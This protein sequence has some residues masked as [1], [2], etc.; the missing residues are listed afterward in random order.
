MRLQGKLNYLAVCGLLGLMLFGCVKTIPVA[1]P[2]PAKRTIP[3]EKSSI[4]AK[5]PEPSPRVQASLTLTE[6]GRLLVEKG[7]ADNA[8]R[9]LE[10]A[11]NLNPGNGQ[12]YY[13]LSEA[14][15]LKHSFQEA[16]EF[17]RLAELHLKDDKT[18]C[19]KL[20]GKPNALQSEKIDQ[21][22]YSLNHI[23]SDCRTQKIV[24]NPFPKN[25][26]QKGHIAEVYTRLHIFVN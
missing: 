20:P 21:W 7:Q 3:P 10:Q 18:G 12:N 19:T 25:R 9:V 24:F 23:R 14:W 16:Q 6:Q 13:Y 8:I 2:A 15:L 26:S 17:N 11:I 1:T 22:Y 5:P 4:P